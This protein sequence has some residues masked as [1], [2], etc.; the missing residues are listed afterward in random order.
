M[1]DEY[2]WKIREGLS[3]K[4]AGNTTVVVRAYTLHWKLGRSQLDLK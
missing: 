2:E 1:I 3:E 4:S